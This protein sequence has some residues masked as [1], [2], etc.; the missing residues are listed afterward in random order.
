MSTRHLRRRNSPGTLIIL[1]LQIEQINAFRQIQ[2]STSE[3][4]SLK[5]Y[6]IELCYGRKHS[7]HTRKLSDLIIRCYKKWF[8]QLTDIAFG[9]I[10]LISTSVCCSLRFVDFVFHMCLD[11]LG[12]ML[13]GPPGTPYTMCGAAARLTDVPTVAT[14]LTDVPTVFLIVAQL[15]FHHSH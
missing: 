15:S 11:A 4:I 3:C 12:S 14:R 5:P 10:L 1:E 8:K 13:D 6:L 2:D 9:L 7:K